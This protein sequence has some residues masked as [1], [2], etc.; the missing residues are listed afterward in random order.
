MLLGLAI[1]VAAGVV[2]AVGMHLVRPLRDAAYPLLV[3]SQAIPIVVL[4]PIFVLAF[5]YG[6][7]PKLAIVALICFFPIT[8][9]LLD[10]LRSTPPE[11]LK[12][13]RSMGASRL[14]T[15]RTVELPASLPYL[16]SGL[17]V[18]ATVSVIGAVFGEWAGADEGLG[19]LVLLGNN[20]LQTPRVYAGI[21][22]LTA[23]GRRAVRARG[24]AERVAVSLEHR[25]K[26]SYEEAGPPGRCW[27]RS[28]SPGCGEKEDVL[29]PS[30]SKQVELMLDY[31]PNADHAGIYAAEAAGH[32]KQAGLD[33]NDPPAARPRGADQAGRG[34]AGRPR[35]LLR[36]RGA[37]RARPGTARRVSVGA[38]V[39]KPLTSIISLPAAKIAPPG[40]PRGQDGRHGGDRLPVRLPAQTILSEARRTR[41]Q[42]EGAQRR[43]RP[44]RRRCSPGKVDAA[45]GAFWN[46]EG[47]GPAAARQAGRGSSGW[48]KPACRPTTSWSWWPTRTRSSATATSS[49]RSSERSRAAPAT[50]ARTPDEAIEGLLDAN[51]DLDPELQ[52]AVVDVTLPLFFPPEGKPF[53]WQDPA[54]WDAFAA[55]D[56]GQQPAGE[57]GRPARGL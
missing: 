56:A 11:L 42:R 3:G 35:D 28:R 31:F 19:R 53:G 34:R 57:P 6:I 7:G 2:V 36:A 39:Q 12:L 24:A 17:K 49:V 32:F 44:R 45:L 27:R 4:A 13:M 14:R 8:V 33:V 18:A 30:G 37:S 15:L 52:R 46:Y 25:E 1:A 20:Q 23:D 38:L 55:L 10:G 40:R 50:C 47:V 48:R 16:F 29:E 43:L 26:G 9:N 22:L 21:V 54:Q 5:D 51:P 41:R